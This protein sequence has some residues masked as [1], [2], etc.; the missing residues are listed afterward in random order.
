MEHKFLSNQMSSISESQIVIEE[1][2]VKGIDRLLLIILIMVPV[3]EIL[4]TDK[5][6]G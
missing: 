2:P 5:M 3:Y 1:L 6:T 4:K